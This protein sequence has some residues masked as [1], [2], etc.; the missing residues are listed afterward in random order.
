M[1]LR[2]ATIA[3]LSVLSLTS[4]AVAFSNSSPRDGEIQ[5]LATKVI[6]PRES[7]IRPVPQVGA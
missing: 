4:P 1:R 3:A 6:R 2:N 7:Q 5:A